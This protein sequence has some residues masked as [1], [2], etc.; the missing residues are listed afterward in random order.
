MLLL[1][2]REHGLIILLTAVAFTYFET[3]Q[4]LGDLGK[5]DEELARISSMRNLLEH[6]GYDRYMWEDFEAETLECLQRTRDAVST[7]DDGLALLNTFNDE[8][9]SMSIIT[10]LKLL[11]S[12]WMKTHVADFEPYLDNMTVPEYCSNHLDPV[13]S[14]MDDM[15]LN[16]LYSI[17]VKPAGIN[18]EVMYLD[19]SI[20]S[21]INTHRFEV[22]GDVSGPVIHLLYR[23]G[24]YDILYRIPPQHGVSQAPLVPQS[25]VYVGLMSRHDQFIPRHQGGP[26]VLT[27]LP[28]MS[29]PSYMQGGC[30]GQNVD[31]TPS[32]VSAIPGSYMQPLPSYNAPPPTPSTPSVPHAQDYALPPISAAGLQSSMELPLRGNMSNGGPFRP[33]MYTFD[34]MF[35][36]MPPPTSTCQTSIFRNSH[37]NTAH[38]LN[39]EF[40]PEQWDPSQEYATT[41]SHRVKQKP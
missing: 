27:L 28:G 26:D 22:D 39:P 16:A 17:L 30:W 33:S 38:Y 36:G 31:F 15:S 6:S 5:F 40:E 1:Q 20:G 19:R 11:A 10:H 37:F 21:E 12:S 4:R 14:E 8:S 7:N 24:H 41:N 29:G 13:Q 23:P 18:L 9:M 35:G 2:S 3:L 25:D 34:G 32:P